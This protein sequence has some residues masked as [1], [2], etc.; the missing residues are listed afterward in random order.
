MANIIQTS[1]DGR[2]RITKTPIGMTIEFLN[3]GGVWVTV[4]VEDYG[5]DNI[6]W[7]FKAFTGEEAEIC[8]D[9]RLEVEVEK[10]GEY[11]IESEHAVMLFR[12]TVSN[13]PDSENAIVEIFKSK[14][15][16]YPSH[17]GI[18]GCPGRWYTGRIEVV[19]A[20][21]VYGYALIEVNR[22]LDV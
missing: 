22:C 15:G 1:A 6:A 19:H 12:M 3:D 10:V 14:T 7:R 2:T 16:I 20:D 13:L 4:D 5:T 11:F 17:L 18:E 21:D 8:D 9:D